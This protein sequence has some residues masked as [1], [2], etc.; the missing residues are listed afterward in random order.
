MPCKYIIHVT[1]PR[2]SKEGE[3]D[4]SKLAESYLSCLK[5][6]KE[7][8]IKEIAF[9][10]ISTGLFGFPKRES[11]CIAIDTIMEWI[12]KE[13]H[14]LDRVIFDVFTHED[15]SIYQELLDNHKIEYDS[16]CLI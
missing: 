6:V 10:C 16:L 4:Y 8:K 12:N 7:Y 5:L 1:G 15:H 2:K 11:A 14:K 13:E 3:L 9:C